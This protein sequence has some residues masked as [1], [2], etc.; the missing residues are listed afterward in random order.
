MWLLCVRES[1]RSYAACTL[2]SVVA[3]SC[4]H[5]AGSGF[6]QDPLQLLILHAEKMFCGTLYKAQVVSWSML[7]RLLTATL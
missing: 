5:A 4:K 3:G 2:C 6:L 1:L 7:H